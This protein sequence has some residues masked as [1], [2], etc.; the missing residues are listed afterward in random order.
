MRDLNWIEM[1]W[2]REVKPE[3][4]IIPLHD[5]VEKEVQGY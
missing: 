3:L 2:N 5:G 1:G 4:Y